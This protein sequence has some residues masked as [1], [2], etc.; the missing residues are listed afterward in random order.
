M[1]DW[2]RVDDILLDMDGTLL[3]LHFD[4]HFWL[5]HLPLRYSELKGMAVDDVRQ[6]LHNRYTSM[7]GTL[8]WYCL[9]YWQE[10]LA[11]NILSLKQELREKIQFRPGA[12]EFLESLQ[13]SGKRV[14]LVSNAHRW[15]IDL[16]FRHLPMEHY[17][18]QVCSSHEHSAPKETQQFWR[19]LQRQLG[20][21]VRRTLFIDDTVDVLDS[22]RKFG[23]DQL[24][25]IAQPDST[26]P[27]R[28]IKGY[29]T[30]FSFAELGQ[31]GTSS[32]S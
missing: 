1:I 8:D 16:K 25:S 21:D 3:D 15:S 29:P 11:L 10:H 2:D 19:S 22:A 5:E 26:R 6:Y 4:N 12:R 9:E 30:L 14:I 28:E 27:A 24:V 23:I 17:F 7:R 31:F 32:G 13:G 20:F 18:D